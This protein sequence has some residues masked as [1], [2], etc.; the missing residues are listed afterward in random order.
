LNG[1][2]NPEVDKLIERQSAE[3]DQQ[4]REQPVW[5]I[6]YKL[7]RKTPDLSYFTAA[8]GSPGS[9]GSKR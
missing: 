6:E 3:A 5:P 7:P 4:R 1:Y 9:A 8:A 2:C